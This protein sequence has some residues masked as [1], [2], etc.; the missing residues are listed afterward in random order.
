MPEA[1]EDGIRFGRRILPA[2]AC[3]LLM[4]AISGCG[5]AAKV[6]A[7]SDYQKSLAAYKVCLGA[8]SS[9]VIACEA[10]RL[11]MEADERAYNDFTAGIQLGGTRSLTI[12]QRSR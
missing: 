9:N 6:N 5:I 10:Q 8:N 7:R 4:L 2:I 11:A 3:V 12:D 1:I